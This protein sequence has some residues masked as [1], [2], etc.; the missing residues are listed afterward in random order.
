[1]YIGNYYFNF[2][3]KPIALTPMS[4]A[5]VLFLL[6]SF[7]IY[8][9]LPK[10]CRV[11]VLAILSLIFVTS[12]SIFDLGFS[13]CFALLVY[14][15]GWFVSKHHKTISLAVCLIV[16]I[17]VLVC[18]KYSN[19]IGLGILRPLGLSFVS[20]KAIS[21]IVD[22]YKGEK[23][24]NNPFY[25]L[26]YLLFF[27]TITAGPIHRYRQFKANLNDT[28]FDYLRAR[29]GGL[30]FVL[31]VFEKMVICD[32]VGSIVA[33]ASLLNGANLLFSIFL[34]SLQIYLDFD[35]Y[36]NIAIGCASM[37]G[38]ETGENFK[39]PYLSINLQSFWRKWHISLS[40]FFRDYVY[41]P[42]GGNRKGKFRRYLNTIIVFV[43]SGIWHGS[44]LNYLFWGLLHGLFSALENII[45]SFIHLSNNKILRLIEELALGIFNFLLVSFLWLF[46]RYVSFNEVIDVIKRLMIHETF[47]FTSIGLT[48]NEVIWFI[49]LMV[50]YVISELLRKYLDLKALYHKMPFI[51]RWLFYILLA[52]IFM[53]FAVYGSGHAAGDF[54]YQ[55]F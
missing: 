53:I 15:L 25:T 55:W 34:Y 8:W 42:L 13:L 22:A 31:G 27:P 37:F 36:S 50:I 32:F 47:S 4:W 16:V 10:K 6:V 30:R 5:F 20:F 26:A 38:I 14:G 51:I 19:E 28:S 39:V 40:S 21:Y 46:F 24:S 11:Y 45:A 18:F 1:M 52:F 54:I 23:I 35:S 7:A 44:T 3:A 41:I 29:D 43:L 48:N 9:L 33:R 12:F 2:P 49:T 17:E